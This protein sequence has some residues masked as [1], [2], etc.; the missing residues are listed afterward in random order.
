[1]NMTALELILHLGV[2]PMSVEDPCTTPSKSEIRRWLDQKAVLINGK[3]PSH[4][5]EVHFPIVELVFFPKGSR[6]TT[7]I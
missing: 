4:K 2:I 5:E 6:K 3:R 1:M 7:V